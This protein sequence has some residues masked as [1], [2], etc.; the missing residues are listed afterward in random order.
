[1]PALKW[2]SDGT[3]PPAVLKSLDETG[4]LL[5][6]EGWCYQNVQA[7]LDAEAATGRPADLPS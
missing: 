2:F 5:A 4:R 1:M 3:S 7:I 6:R